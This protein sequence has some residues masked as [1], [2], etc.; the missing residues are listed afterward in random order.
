MEKIRIDIQWCDKNFGASF[1]ENVPGALAITADT[2]ES[3]QKAIE[4]T[5]RFHVDGMIE[6]GDNVPQWLLDGDYEFEYKYLDIATLLKVCESYS[7]LTAISRASGINQRQLSHYVNGV[8]KPR[9]NQRQRIIDG[10]HKIGKELIAI[11]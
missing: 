7:S 4:E 9:P 11:V 3:L 1:G 8:K 10:I 5:L 2:F 6:D